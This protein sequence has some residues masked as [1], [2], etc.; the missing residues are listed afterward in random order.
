MAVL[1]WSYFIYLYSS[2][3]LTQARIIWE[4]E[5]AIGKMTPSDWS[6]GKPV[7]NSL[8]S[9][10]TWENPAHRGLY[11]PWENSPGVYGK[12]AEQAM[13]CKPVS[14]CGLWFWIPALTS[15]YDGLWA[16][17]WKNFLQVALGHVVHHS[18]REPTGTMA[19][20]YT[21]RTAQEPRRSQKKEA[22]AY[23]SK[24][25]AIL[26]LLQTVCI[27]SLW[28]PLTQGQSLFGWL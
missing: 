26:A 19:I 16:I 9:W 8:D 13:E 3:N 28:A 2:A 20:S 21:E 11:S 7:G 17:G 23:I 4:E 1:V 12:Q 25:D 5:T 18:K 15:F 14:T 24:K 27:P 10:L 22:Q 6:V